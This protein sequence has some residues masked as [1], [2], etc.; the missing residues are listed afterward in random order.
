MRPRHVQSALALNRFNKEG[1]GHVDAAGW[2]GEHSLKKIDGIDFGTEI[3]VV[4]KSGDAGERN[5]RG[6]AIV[7]VAGRGQCSQGYAMEA[8][9]ERDD[10][11]TACY[12]ARELERGF[13]GIGAGRAGKL[14]FEVHV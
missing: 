3:A 1:G 13:H 5:T 8:V 14:D 9:G 7:A 12:L 10:G 11:R 6:A 2:I 4:G